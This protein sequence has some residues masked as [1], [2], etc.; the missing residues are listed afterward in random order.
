MGEIIGKSR[1][2]SQ[3]KYCPGMDRFVNLEARVIDEFNKAKVVE[4]TKCDCRDICGKRCNLFF[5]FGAADFRS[6][7]DREAEYIG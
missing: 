6:F 3:R 1:V 5:K 4:W 2:A 7:S